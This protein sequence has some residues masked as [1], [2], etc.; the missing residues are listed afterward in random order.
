MTEM[1]RVSYFTKHRAEDYYKCLAA[2]IGIVPRE[3]VLDVGCGDGE[4]VKYLRSNE[5]HADGIEI[6]N[7]FGTR[8]KEKYRVNLYANFDGLPEGLY[9]H[10][11]FISSLQ[12]MENPK[13]YIINA[14]G[15]LI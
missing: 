11:I 6:L 10:V 9:D 5:S 12:Y 8:A 4:F 14:K 15:R 2:Q 1:D 13:S 3:K 7:E